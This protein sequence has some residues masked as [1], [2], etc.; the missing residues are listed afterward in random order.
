MFDNPDRF[1]CNEYKIVG[2][3]TVLNKLWIQM[4]FSTNFSV[5]E[6]PLCKYAGLTLRL[7]RVW[8]AAENELRIVGQS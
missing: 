1:V 7:K 5:F 2:R 3:L 8:L 6:M 4:S